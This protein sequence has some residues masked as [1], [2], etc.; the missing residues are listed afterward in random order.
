MRY[1]DDS[2]LI[3]ENKEDLLQF[4]DIVVE[5]NRKKGI[6]LPKD[7]SNC[8]QLLKQRD[9]FKYLGT[10]ISSDR[11]NNTEIASVIEQAKRDF[12]D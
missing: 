7:R 11:H 6:E 10:L 12:R 3:A 4:L 1:G 5:E 2:A 9:K 8:H